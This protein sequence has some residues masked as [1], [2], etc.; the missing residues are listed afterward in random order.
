MKALNDR[1]APRYQRGLI[2]EAL[3]KVGVILLHDVEY[4]FPGETPMIL[5]QKPVHLCKLFV[6]HDHHALAA[7]PEYTPTY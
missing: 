3:G 7:M 4:R 1:R 6:S 5:G 2:R